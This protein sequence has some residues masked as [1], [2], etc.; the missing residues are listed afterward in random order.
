MVG[1]SAKSRNSTGF[2]GVAPEVAIDS[3][4]LNNAVLVYDFHNQAWVGL[5]QGAVMSVK[6]FF[7]VNVGGLD[8][9]CFLGNDGWVNLMEES[10]AG[11]QIADGGQPG[12]LG[13]AEIPTDVTLKG[14]LFG[15]AGQRILQAV[16]YLAE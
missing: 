14:H 13:W 7:H 15:Q 12:G 2:A 8:R 3:S 9:L 10:E 5:D 11:D 1:A 16:K 4:P 6:E